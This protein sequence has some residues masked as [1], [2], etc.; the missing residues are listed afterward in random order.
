MRIRAKRLPSFLAVFLL[1]VPGLLAQMTRQQRAAA[2][3][4]F[5]RGG[6]LHEVAQAAGGRYID[7]WT[8]MAGWV[9]YLSLKKLARASELVLIG[10]PLENI[11]KLS[12][13]GRYLFTSNQVRVEEGIKG[14]FKTGD[15]IT[16]VLPGG[17]FTW[18]DGTT[19]QINTPDAR[20]MVNGLRYVLYLLR[21][22]DT[23]EFAATGGPQGIFELSTDGK[24]KAYA[25]PETHTLA[26]EMSGRTHREFVDAV[27][28]GV[29]EQD[30]P[31]EDTP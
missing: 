8:N 13:D 30:K 26:K 11:C 28:R 24:V 5:S 22:P 25:K 18:D 1:A 21:K 27:L 7:N 23:Q 14:Q 19:V 2:D 4:V 29:Q 12:A 16:V 9:E 17:K 3:E 10:T 31:D 20:K 6:S 15:T